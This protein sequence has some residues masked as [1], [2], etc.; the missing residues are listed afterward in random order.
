MQSLIHVTHC[1]AKPSF[2]RSASRKDHSTRSKA[3]L[4][5]VLIA[6]NFDR[7]P[8]LVRNAWKTSC[9]TR[10]LSVIKRQATKADW[11][12]EIIFGRHFLRRLLITF[13]M[14]L[15]ETLHK[16]I[17]LNSVISVGLF[18]FGMR[19]MFV[20]FKRGSMVPLEKISFTVWRTTSAVM[21]QYF[22]KKRLVISSGPGALYGFMSNIAL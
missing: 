13:E 1:A 5:S 10:I 2:R 19:Q 15:Y 11:V 4:M 18:V 6:T 20:W 21:P 22:W 16:L 9:G 12:S 7:H 14:T 8:G 3:L 17:G